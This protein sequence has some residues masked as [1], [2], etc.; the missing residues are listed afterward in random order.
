MKILPLLLVLLS[1]SS[2]VFA[3]DGRSYNTTRALVEI[4][5]PKA[6]RNPIRSVPASSWR[7]VD[8]KAKMKPE[9]NQY[10][11]IVCEGNFYGNYPDL[12]IADDLYGSAGNFNRR[13][14]INSSTTV[15][16]LCHQQQDT[17]RRENPRLFK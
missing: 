15:M 2:S 16:D 3:A 10:I 14:V 4:N 11:A 17:M 12:I 7:A 5:D 1:I 13:F 9:K 8:V 6:E